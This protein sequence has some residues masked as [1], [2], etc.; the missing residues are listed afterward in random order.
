VNHKRCPTEVELLSF[1]DGELSPEQLRRLDDHVSSCAACRTHVDEWRELIGDIQAPLPAP[2]LSTASHQA[3]AS[4]T[5]A[6]VAAVLSRLDEPG[7]SAPNQRVLWGWIST[8]TAAAAAVLLWVRLAPPPADVATQHPLPSVVSAAAPNAE[9]AADESGQFTA[10]GNASESS[11]SRD[12]GIQLYT[13]EQPLKP[14]EPGGKLRQRTALTA[15]LRNLAQETAHLLLF[16]VDANHVVHWIAPAFTDPDS[17]P[18]AL[19]VHPSRSEQPL[20]SSVDFDDLAVGP[21][22]VVALITK[23][24]LHVSDIEKLTPNE[25]TG[26]LVARFP[27]A[28][29][30]QVIVEVVP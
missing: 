9:L 15:G 19:T 2:P 4:E 12:V 3:A 1:V 11:L 29:V 20:P 7:S 17:D 22:R 26:D 6:H 25:L 13:F 28:V 23:T 16:G 5:A 30:R 10:R 18:P 14:L 8:V 27:R 21:L 24:P